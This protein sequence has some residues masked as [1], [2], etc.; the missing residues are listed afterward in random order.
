VQLFQPVS[1][2]LQKRHELEGTP[3]PFPSLSDASPSRPSSGGPAKTVLDTTSQLAFPSLAPSVP[4]AKAPSKSAWA[5][6]PRIKSNISKQPLVSDS[7]TLS[8]IDL[9]NTGKDGKHA[10]LGEVMKQVMSKY[11]VKL[12]ASANQR[13]NQTTFH[14]RAE[15]QKELEKSK[16]S[17]FALLSPIVSVSSPRLACMM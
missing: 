7:F 4:P 5:A 17:L 13:T 11:K 10:T 14:L 8:A 1:L 15:S 16:R 2:F 12:E 6:G 9:S 3:D